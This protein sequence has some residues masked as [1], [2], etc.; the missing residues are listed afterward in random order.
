MISSYVTWELLEE[1]ANVKQKICLSLVF[2]KRTL[3]L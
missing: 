3:L 2:L 1:L